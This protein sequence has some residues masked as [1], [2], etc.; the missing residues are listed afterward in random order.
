MALVSANPSAGGYT[1]SMPT[2][3]HRNDWIQTT[4]VP[5]RERSYADNLRFDAGVTIPLKASDTRT[6]D[7]FLLNTV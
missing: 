2:K 5:L 7:S 4:K 6:S 1:Q 3:R